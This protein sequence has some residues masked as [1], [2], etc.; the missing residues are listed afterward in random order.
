MRKAVHPLNMRR[1][2]RRVEDAIEAGQYSEARDLLD[3]IE[4]LDPG[5]PDAEEL[6]WQLPDERDDAVLEDSVRDASV[7][8]D[9]KREIELLIEKHRI[10]D[11]RWVLEQTL[12]N[13]DNTERSQL[14]SIEAFV[15]SAEIR[16]ERFRAAIE[17]AL[18]RLE[19]NHLSEAR[20]HFQKL[21][22]QEPQHPEL[23]TLES[24]IEVYAAVIRDSV[25]RLTKK[26]DSLIEEAKA[27]IG[28]G[29]FAQAR[30][31]LLEASEFNHDSKILAETTKHLDSAEAEARA[32]FSQA[33]HRLDADDLEGAKAAR[34]ELDTLAPRYPDRGVLD[35]RIAEAEEGHQ[36]SEEHRLESEVGRLLTEGDLAS[37]SSTLENST[38]TRSDRINKLR[39]RLYRVREEAQGARAEAWKNLETGE[40]I[41][42]ERALALAKSKDSTDLENLRIENAIRGRR[43]TVAAT[44]TPDSAISGDSSSS[45][46]D[47]PNAPG[48][49][50]SPDVSPRRTGPIGEE[51][52]RPHSHQTS[53]LGWAALGLLVLIG[54]AWGAHSF[55]EYSRRTP[56][57]LERV[58]IDP[59]DLVKF[60]CRSGDP[61][62]AEDERP[63]LQFEKAIHKFELAR[64]EVR[65]EDY[66]RCVRAGHCK[67]TGQATTEEDEPDTGNLPRTH[68]SWNEANAF[69]SWM[70]GRLPTEIEWELA[71]R[72]ASSGTSSNSIEPD[73]AATTKAGIPATVLASSKSPGSSPPPLPPGSNHGAAICCGEDASDGWPQA[74]PVNAVGSNELGL[75]GMA[76]NVAEWTASKYQNPLEPAHEPISS[77]DRVDFVAVRGGSWGHPPAML[78]PT[79]RQAVPPEIRSGLI[80]F[81][82][83]WP[84]T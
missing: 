15:R 53:K 4:Q 16:D 39:Q 58:W 63:A 72:S 80:G 79:A 71:A 25:E 1:L 14:A 70:G 67:E 66:S 9:R 61:L 44:I 21:K 33:M 37:A 18:K 29:L 7:E 5:N 28:E 45:K 78:R 27:L 11:A 6:R 10:S 31:R 47:S 55:V 60:G 73:Q 12:E 59:G 30:S 84:K 24:R 48:P 65:R 69:C 23:A 46:G 81:R 83:A 56:P 26:L 51:S 36:R 32:R 49:N 64:A 43:K 57:R 74:A 68:V 76:G 82:C 19:A 77:V 34:G 62:C 13:A 3:Q 8:E 75:L 52:A 50:L 17:E 35:S 41:R 20:E 38:V 42:A 22:A 54:F 40:L 2:L